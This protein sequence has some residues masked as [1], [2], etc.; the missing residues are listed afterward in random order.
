VRHRPIGIGIQG[1]ADA[2]ILM[3]FPFESEEACLLNKQ[4]FETIYYGAL[5][6]SCEM[7]EKEGPYQT[8]PGSPVSK[9]ILQYDM[10]GVTPTSLHDWASLKAKIAKHGV[11]NSLLLAPMPTASTAQILGNNESVE[12]Y[13]SNI[14][15]RRVLSGEFQVVNQHL[16][17]DLVELGIW[18]DDI[19]NDIISF[20]GSIQNIPEIPADI[21]QLY[22]TVWEISQKTVIRQAADRGAFID[23]SQSL[24]IHIA[25]PNFGKMSS[26]HFYGWECG[27]K[28]GMYYLRTKPAAQAIQ[29]TVDKAKVKD[30]MSAKKDKLIPDSDQAPAA[31]ADL[32][33]VTKNMSTLVCSIQNRDDCLSCGS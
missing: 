27:L 14:Y 7:A 23:Q 21:K 26:M 11:R 24:N 31:A 13:T 16:L 32:S 3:R 1:L 20:N 12:A 6:A 29:F 9:G 19:K 30:A 5:E 28:T 17:K 2:Y 10:W 33:E 4:I 22:K 8:Y 15:T 25:E 18:S